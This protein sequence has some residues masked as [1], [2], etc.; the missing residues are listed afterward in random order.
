MECFIEGYL[1]S[2]EIAKDVIEV[3]KRERVVGYE[4]SVSKQIILQ[5]T[6]LAMLEP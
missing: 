4:L 6:F 1:A 3:V 2:A 5:P